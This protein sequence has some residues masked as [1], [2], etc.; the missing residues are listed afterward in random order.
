[1][2]I[3]PAVVHRAGV[4]RREVQQALVGERLEMGIPVAHRDAGTAAGQRRIREQ[5]GVPAPQLAQHLPV[6]VDLVGARAAVG[7]VRGRPSAR[8][9]ASHA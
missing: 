6:G 1:M 4:H 7:I 2:R 5:V 3:E 9:S 8:L